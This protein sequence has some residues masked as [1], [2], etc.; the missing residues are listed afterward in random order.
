MSEGDLLGVEAWAME[1][2]SKRILV[3]ELHLR[4]SLLNVQAKNIINNKA[5]GHKTVSEFKKQ[6]RIKDFF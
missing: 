6:A 3:L 2:C 4:E 1:M 5:K